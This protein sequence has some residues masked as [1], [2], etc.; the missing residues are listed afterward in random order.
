MKNMRADFPKNFLFGVTTFGGQTQ[1]R[2][3]QNTFTAPNGTETPDEMDRCLRSLDLVQSA[4]FDCLQ[5]SISWTRVLP[6]GRGLM[7]Q[8]G[9]DFYDQLADALSERGIRPCAILDHRELPPSLSDLGG[10]R[11]RDIADW[12][13]DF[14]ETIMGR[15]G[16][17]MFSVAPF[18]KPA[19][20]GWHSHFDNTL[21]PDMRA[22]ARAMHHALLAHGRAIEA[23]RGLGMTN[24]G[25]VFD[26]EWADPADDLR[27]RFFLDGVL[28][29]AYPKD[30]LDH[31]EPYLPTGWQQ[32][33][34]AIGRPID[35]CGLTS[36]TWKLAASS[37]AVE[38]DPQD[39]PQILR[40]IMRD[41]TKE[42]PIYITANSQPG[43]DLRQD[44]VQTESL[45][46]HL[47]VVHAAL[48]LGVPAKGYFLRPVSEYAF[49]AL[50]SALAG[51]SVS[52]P[53]AQPAGTI[54]AHWNLVADIGGTN[55]RLGVISN[56]ELVDLRKYPTGA[57]PELLDAFHTLRDEVGTDPRAVVAAGAGPV[58]N[59]TIRLTNAQ[60]DLSE[61]DIGQATGARHTFVINDFT[62]A[63]WSVAEIT[64][65][66]VQVLQGAPTPPV[67]TRLVVGP[68][69]GLGVGALVHSEGRYHTAS[70]EGGHIGLSPRH[71]DEVEVFGAARHIAAECFFDDSLTLEAEMFLSGTGLPILYRAVGMAAGQTDTPIRSAKDILHDAQAGTD[72]IAQKT[73][74]M[75]TT[76]LG[77]LMGDLAVAYM[78]TGGVFLVGG[79]AEKNRWLF[80]DA[81]RDA[82]NAGGRFSGLRRSMNLYVSEQAEFGIVGANNFC[83]S[84]LAR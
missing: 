62:A 27:N 66:E 40:R 6:E 46:Q 57:L 50:K 71:V 16:D 52:E 42:L 25:A 10:W 17:R 63:A 32:D 3:D 11:N 68:G 9:L 1:S 30:V 72:P 69:T 80:K 78:P 82:F 79:V 21:T 48:E 8:S 58:N 18:T 70:G 31:L 7:D 76:H 36:G 43:G 73:A 65:D 56:G 44:E 45:D 67:G 26:L 64:G 75:F 29:G 74:H 47:N 41:Y 22:T 34:D 28:N 54:Q 33:F 61:D 15:I 55:T 81:F 14:T 19:G 51:G 13:A 77:A 5:F 35:W 20:I 38:T 83:K 60:L 84:A 49:N 53:L 37:G 24:L 39:A 4:G 59:G 23:M 12:F 2:A